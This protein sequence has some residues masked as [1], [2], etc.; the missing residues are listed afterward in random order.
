MIVFDLVAV[1]LFDW[2]PVY[3]IDYYIVA[4]YSDIVYTE[5]VDR[6]VVDG[7]VP[8]AVVPCLFSAGERNLKI[9]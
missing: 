4:A 7:I 2:K 1:Q 3:C 5:C 9:K 6:I 8:R